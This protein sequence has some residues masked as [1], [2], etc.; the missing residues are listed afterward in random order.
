VPTTVEDAVRDPL[1]FSLAATRQ[2]GRA[3]AEAASAQWWHQVGSFALNLGSAIAGDWLAQALL[4]L[5][6]GSGVAA[7][8][9]VAG[10]KL[11]QAAKVQRA[12]ADYSAEADATETDEEL[13]A[14][15]KAH[16]AKQERAGIHAQ[17]AKVIGK[18]PPA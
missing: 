15:R 18:P 9:A 4:L 17:V 1:A 16:R 8:L 11:W 10:R 13:K 6:I 2:A 7:P 3:E 5:G 12:M 14:V